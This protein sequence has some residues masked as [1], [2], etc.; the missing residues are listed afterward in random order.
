MK[1][2][3][4]PIEKWI[5]IKNYTIFSIGLT[6]VMTGKNTFENDYC[7]KT[8]YFDSFHGKRT[9]VRLTS[10]CQPTRMGTFGFRAN[11]RLMVSVTLIFSCLKSAPKVLA[12]TR[13]G[14]TSKSWH[15]WCFAQ[16]S[17]LF[18]GFP[19]YTWKFNIRLI[20]CVGLLAT[21]AMLVSWIWRLL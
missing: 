19:G 4:V 9:R 16:R 7:R 21:S 2:S 6:Y 8:L 5:K 1:K 17:L 11:H 13:C 3:Q 15:R 18:R 20:V 12:V 10:E 14:Y